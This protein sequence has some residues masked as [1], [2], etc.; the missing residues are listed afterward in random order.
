MI[1]TDMKMPGVDGMI[2]MEWLARGFSRIRLIIISGYDDF[3]YMR[4]AITNKAVDYI[5][6]PIVWKQLNDA[7]KRAIDESE[8]LP[9]AG[10]DDSSMMA[11]V[12]RYILYRFIWQS[13]FCKRTNFVKTV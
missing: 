7:L 1:I 8:G 5:L 13:L 4:S 3:S 2:L 11:D 6:K 10:R 9:Q 12:R